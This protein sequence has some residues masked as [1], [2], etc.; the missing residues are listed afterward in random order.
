MIRKLKFVAAAGLI[1]ALV[2]L[3]LGF[4]LAGRDW[5]LAGNWWRVSQSTCGETASANAQIT[6][7]FTAED[8]LAIALAA[9]V[10]YQPGPKGEAV[11][12]GDAALLDHVRI[13]GGRLRLDCDPGWSAPRFDIALT[14][15][16][17]KSWELL[18][19]TDLSLTQIDQPQLRVSIKGS[20]SIAASGTAE[21]IRLAISGSG[22]AA[23][24][25]LAAKSAEVD[26]RGNGDAQVTAQVDADVSISGNGN[27]EL[28]GHPKLRSSDVRGYGN[29]VLVQ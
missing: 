11:V 27:V 15:P 1:A 22:K 2:F 25:D 20:G 4:S 28:F 9:S 14:G 18:G 6:L 8:N 12:S 29:I 3:T 17:I 26:I 10:R 5:A 24:K 7:P 19:N 13:E 23:L 21:T 16:A